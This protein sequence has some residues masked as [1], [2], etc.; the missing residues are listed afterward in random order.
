MIRKLKEEVI[1]LKQQIL[2][3]SQG[4]SIDSLVLN[5]PPISD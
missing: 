1:M 3:L 4:E 2:V 5:L